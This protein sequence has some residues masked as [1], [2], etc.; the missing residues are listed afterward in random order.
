MIDM[1]IGKSAA[2]VESPKS[3]ADHISDI[4]LDYLIVLV[5]IFSL[6]KKFLKNSQKKA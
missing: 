6:L 3:E 5:F 1:I 4:N 2:E